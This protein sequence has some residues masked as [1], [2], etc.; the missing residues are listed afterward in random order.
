MTAGTATVQRAMAEHVAGRLAPAEQLYRD[1]LA[2]DPDNIEALHLLGLVRLQQGEVAAALPLLEQAARRAPGVADYHNRLG[3]ALAAA[4]RADDAIAAY[5]QAI[6]CQAD[7]PEAHNNLAIL[8]AAT[9]QRQAAIEAYRTA[10]ATN[11]DFAEAHNGLAVALAE[12][13]QFGDAEFHYRRALACNPA[14]VEAGANLGDLLARMGRHDEAIVAL[15]AALDRAPTNLE[16]LL[17]LADTFARAGEIDSARATAKQALEAFPDLAR[18]HNCYG[19]ICRQGGEIE[20]AARHLARAIELDPGLAEAHGNQ[21]LTLLTSGRVE[22]AATAAARAVD[23]APEIGVHRMNLGMIQLL[24]GDFEK[25]FE[26]YRARFDS[27][28]S[29]VT[30]RRFS[31][32]AWT[33]EAIDGRR[34]MAWGEQGVG[35]EIMFASMLGRLSW[36]TARCLVECDPRLVPLLR[37]SIDG[38]E[39][40]GRVDPPDAALL[41]PAIDMTIGFGD[42]A[43]ALGLGARDFGDPEPY[44][45]ADQAARAA[46]KSRLAALGDGL[47]I[48]VAWRSRGANAFFNAEKSTDLADWYPI[49]A[50]TGACFVD[51]QYGDTGADVAHIADRLGVTIVEDRGVD[52]MRDLDGFAALIDALD[53]VV[54]TSNTTAHLAGALG[55]EVWVLLPHVPDWRWQLGREDSL[56]YPRARLIR[57]PAPGDWRGVLAAAAAALAERTGT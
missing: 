47:K 9:G 50:V 28:Q 32:A 7:H 49:F 14:Y 16:A 3:A 44:L 15:R 18:S 38:I 2:R 42:I 20:T 55:K 46:A 19:M 29:W 48:G 43:L 37:R 25:G 51:L 33:G 6:A 23:L 52:Q 54:T 22:A 5:R 12:D 30:A 21:A 35:E 26:G 41:D 13:A 10:L 27:R 1:A 24:R 40:H 39:V 56:W 34:V 31:G 4:G 36:R 17:C 11:P 57:Q 45:I 8:L 53:L